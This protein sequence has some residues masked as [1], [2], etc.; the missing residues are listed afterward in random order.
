MD[1]VVLKKKKMVYTWH[2]WKSKWL[3]SIMFM[4]GC[5]LKRKAKGYVWHR[6]KAKLMFLIVIIRGCCYHPVLVVIGLLLL[7]GEAMLAYKT[8]SGTKGFKKLLHLTLQFSALVLGAIGLWVAWKFHN[9]R[10]IGNF[11]SLHSWL[12]LACLFLFAIQW[13]GGVCN[14]LV[15]GW[16]SKKPSFTYEWHF[17]ASR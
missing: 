10:G 8:V 4:D 15:P 5:C 17:Y 12:G 9:D 2:K 11:Y 16:F 14:I 6:W 13:G 3:F 1:Q 7:N